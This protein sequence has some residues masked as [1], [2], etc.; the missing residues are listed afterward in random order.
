MSKIES[1]I[2][3]VLEIKQKRGE[4]RADF[5]ARVAKTISDASDKDYEAVGAGNIGEQ[6]LDWYNSA[7]DALEAKKTPP[8]FPDLAKEEAKEEKTTRRRSS[9]KEEAP[10]KDEPYEPAVKDTVKVVNKRGK[11][12][13]GVVVEVDADLLVIETAE[14]EEEFQRSR[15]E[16]VT[17]VGGKKS[18]KK[19][20]VVDEAEADELA[21]GV[22]V[23]VV[24]KRGKEFVGKIVEIDDEILVIETDDGEEEFQRSRLESVTP[25]TTKK[26]APKEEAKEE[27]SS[28]RR[29]SAKEEAKDEGDD[30]KGGKRAAGGVGIAIRQ[31][32]VDALKADGEIPSKADLL[33]TVTKEYPDCKENTLSLVHAEFTRLI[34]M[35]KEAKLLKL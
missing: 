8:D 25:K 1:H 3:D 20:E 34:E 9:A 18:S 7:C 24:N 35:L 19:E 28:R 32:L 23:K 13:T 29:S 16:S 2:S 26:S 33:K 4:E 31:S 15:L 27:K 5:L 10:A 6:T 17:L 12:F 30:A 21:V 14:G 11:E 22:E